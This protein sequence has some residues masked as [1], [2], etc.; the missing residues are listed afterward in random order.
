[1]RNNTGQTG[2]TDI[3][4]Y[5][6]KLMVPYTAPLMTEDFIS[7]RYHPDCG[8][9]WWNDELILGIDGVKDVVCAQV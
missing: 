2:P 6:K 5:R 9:A 3:R 7:G 1:M 8:G 4:K